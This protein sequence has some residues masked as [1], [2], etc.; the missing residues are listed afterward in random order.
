METFIIIFISYV[1][2]AIITYF[3]IAW[4]DGKGKVN[5]EFREFAPMIAAFWLF[6]LVII[7]PIV[8][9]MNFLESIYLKIYERARK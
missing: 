5:T 1:V 8:L 4:F 9:M 6:L 7:I 2:V 3:L